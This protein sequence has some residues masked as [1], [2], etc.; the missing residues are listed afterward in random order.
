MSTYGSTPDYDRY[1]DSMMEA[2]FAENDTFL[3]FCEEHGL[4]PE[5]NDSVDDFEAWKVSEMEA[6]LNVEAL[7]AERME[8][9]LRDG[10]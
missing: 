7:L 4:D 5:D 3:A 2:Q 1:L 8:M 9:E 6:D 10:E